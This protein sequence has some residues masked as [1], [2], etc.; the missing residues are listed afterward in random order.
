MALFTFK[1]KEQ[2]VPPMQQKPQGP[3]TESVIAMRDQ[4]LSNNQI[5]QN[6]YRE[7]YSSSDVFDAM[8]QVNVKSSVENLNPD[9][10]NYPP[11][12]QNQQ[13]PSNYPPQNYPTQP[14]NYSQNYPQNSPQPYQEVDPSRIEEVTEAIVNEKLSEILKAINKISEWKEKTDSRLTVVETQQKEL[15]Q[16]F[17]NLHDAI[18]GKVGEYDQNIVNLGAEIKA[19]EKVFQ[20]VLPTLADNVAE[21]SKITDDMKKFKK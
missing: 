18:L 20:K 4:G 6:L 1:K 16:G 11:D 3:P 7:G 10:F 19:M 13:V 8:N 2:E 9:Y 5:I 17:D 12:Q 21:L 15:K 14:S